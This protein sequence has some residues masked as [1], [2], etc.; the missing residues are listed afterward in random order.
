MNQVKDDYKPGDRVKHKGTG[1]VGTIVSVREGDVAKALGG[2][3]KLYTIDFG[4]SVTA[5]FDIEMNMGE[6]LAEA[7]EPVLESVG[8]IKEQR[9]QN[10]ACISSAESRRDSTNGQIK[11]EPFFSPGTRYRC[12]KAVK[13][14]FTVGNIYDQSS[15]ATRW[16]GYL[17]NDK[18]EM[19]CWPQIDEIAHSSELF[20]MKPE[21]A[22]PRLFFEPVAA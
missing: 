13:G 19:H 21:D 22:D 12:I 8:E 14:C 2:R 20:N 17:R 4:R 11:D 3:R 1:E 15:E 5:A 6:Y 7:L 18:G 9:E 10:D 16:H